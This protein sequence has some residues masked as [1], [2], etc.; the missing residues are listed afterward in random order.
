MP[1]GSGRQERLVRHRRRTGLPQHRPRPSTGRS[2]RHPSAPATAPREYSRSRSGTPTTVSP[3]AAILKS[4]TKH[5]EA[6]RPHFRRRPHV[7]SSQGLATHRLSLR[8]QPRTGF[9]RTD[10]PGRRP[11]RNRPVNRRRRE[12][13][14]AQPGRLPCSGVRYG[15]GRLGRRRARQH[16]PVRTV[17]EETRKPLLLT[18][19]CDCTVYRVM[20]RT[21]T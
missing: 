2:T 6:L 17:D 19:G 14:E 21:V 3:S 18:M 10:P 8:R 1:G 20:R 5:R 15:Q 9:A 4:R 16:R 7:E 11:D 12:L 13:D